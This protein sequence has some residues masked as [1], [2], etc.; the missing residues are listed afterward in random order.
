MNATPSTSTVLSSRPGADPVFGRFGGL[1]R[2]TLRDLRLQWFLY[3]TQRRKTAVAAPLG[4]MNAH[5]LRDIGAPDEMIARTTGPRPAY[6]RHGIPF[7]LGAVLV[8]V[9]LT[10]TAT[11]TSAETGAPSAASGKA[12]AQVQV[13]SAPMAGVF[14]GEYIN[15]A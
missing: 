12:P 9:A 14:V 2:T 8:V 5:M 3:R 11:P 10:G 13:S 7:G 6:E 1:I 15:G 4:E